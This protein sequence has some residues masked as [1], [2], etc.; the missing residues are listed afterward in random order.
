MPSQPHRGEGAR[1][2]PHKLQLPTWQASQPGHLPRC[3]ATCCSQQ[4]LEVQ[5]FPKGTTL[6]DRKRTLP[7]GQR[8]IRNKGSKRTELGEGEKGGEG[9]AVD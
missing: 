5:L 2:T 1:Q 9:Q 6:T 4:L 3:P 8:P 7:Q